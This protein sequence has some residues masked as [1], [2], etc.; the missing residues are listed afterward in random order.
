MTKINECD[1]PWSYRI[2]LGFSE[3]SVCQGNGGR[4]VDETDALDA[5]NFSS[6]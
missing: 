3:K 1:N 2:K 6:I 4:F 5:S